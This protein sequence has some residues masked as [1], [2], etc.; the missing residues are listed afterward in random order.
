MKTFVTRLRSET[1]KYIYLAGFMVFGLL[2]LKEVAY[3]LLFMIYSFWLWRRQ[4]FLVCLGVLLLGLSVI[5]IRV[6]ECDQNDTGMIMLAGRI[7]K[8][9]NNKAK[10]ITKDKYLLYFD[11]EPDLVPGDMVLVK[12]DL[13]DIESKDIRH[14]FSYDTYL[15]SAG[16]KAAVAVVEYEKTGHRFDLGIINHSVRDYIRSVFNSP[17]EEYVLMLVTGDD[18]TMEDTTEESM[19]NLGISHL[20]AISGMHVGILL[21]LVDKLLRKLYLCKKTYRFLMVSF[22][23]CY[24]LV[25]GFPVSI[26]RA[27]ILAMVLLLVPKRNSWLS[28]LDILSLTMIGFLLVNPR[29]LDQLGFVLSFLVSYVLILGR[30]L[31]KA[32]N[33]LVG[34]LKVTAIANLFALPIVLET[35]H[36]FGLMLPVAN[37]IFVMFVEILLLPG[38]IVT[39][40]FPFLEPIYRVLVILFEYY[41]S[42]LGKANLMIP[43]NFPGPVVKI[44]YYFLLLQVFIHF[45]DRQRQNRYLVTLA[46]IILLSLI[47][48]PF[49]TS[50]YIMDV[51]DGD[52]TY[53]ETQECNLLIDTGPPDDYDS[54][55]GYFEGEN[56]HHLDMIVITH[57]HDDHY[58]ELDDLLKTL[59]VNKVVSNHIFDGYTGES[60][61]LMPEKGDS[62]VCGNLVF[63]V[64]HGNIG[65]ENENE[66]SLVLSVKIGFEYWLFMADAEIKGE[67]DALKQ[68]DGAYDVVKV[69]HHGSNTSST[70]EFVR[71]TQPVFALISVGRNQY[72]HP[73]SDVVSRWLESGSHVLRTDESG[74][75]IFRYFFS[76]FRIAQTYDRSKPWFEWFIDVRFARKGR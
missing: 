20:F 19:R 68:L 22:L 73:D 16:V 34:T 56:I 10:I 46:A 7:I 17:S 14:L 35:N 39:L 23:V 41:L 69:A 53:I 66:N 37:V 18:S 48:N 52:C 9:E 15:C 50:V 59:S 32:G 2:S 76:A 3:A 51:G 43:F 74:T 60:E 42:W 4:K 45:K 70:P 1:G 29:Y 75:L 67:T 49:V 21:G 58:G 28:R 27:S 65:D 24:N 63:H 61:L 71:A 72:G 62:V 12:G 30:N 47:R 13:L 25:A 36:D 31:L 5:H 26:V 40:F 44:L 54:L 55:I 33:R 11:D 64:L 8:V 57:W 38:A 6:S